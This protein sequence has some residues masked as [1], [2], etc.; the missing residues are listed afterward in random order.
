MSLVILFGLPGTGKT[1]TGKV[2]EKYFGFYFYDGDNDLTP[3][4]KKAIN[5]KTVFT[6]QM[7]DK[8]FKILTNKIKKLS[9]KYKNL[10]IAQTFIKEKYRLQ[11][12]KL[13]P[14][15]KFILIETKKDIREK[16]LMKRIN[17]PLDLEYARKM[18][19]NFDK[20][21]IKHQIINNDFNGVNGIKKQ[22]IN[23]LSSPT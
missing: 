10:A 17:Y 2:F 12:I 9:K 16:R 4:M 21:I 7:R 3:E 19:G 6:D 8:F 20:P 18:E 14:K 23:I 15:T 1:Y 22:T 5:S 11:L 13:I